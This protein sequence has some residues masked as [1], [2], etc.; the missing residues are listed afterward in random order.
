[1]AQL[2][3]TS[4]EALDRALFHRMLWVVDEKGDKLAG[5]GEITD[6]ETCWCFT[7]A[8]AWKAGRYHLVADTRLEDLAGNSI[9]QLFEIDEPHQTQRE[10]KTQ[11]VRIPF[12]V[13]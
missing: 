1:M 13:R 10:N 3:V 6:Q 9:G 2:V 4:P 8:A 5:S 11:T 7:P 12:E